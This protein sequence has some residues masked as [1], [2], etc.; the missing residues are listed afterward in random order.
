MTPTDQVVIAAEVADICAV[1][2]NARLGC[3]KSVDFCLLLAVILFC[4]AVAS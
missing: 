3:R 4:A 1:F 2:I